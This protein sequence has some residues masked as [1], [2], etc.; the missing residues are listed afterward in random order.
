MATRASDSVVLFCSF[1]KIDT[2]EIYFKKKSL[3][4]ETQL[5]ASRHVFGVKEVI[6]VSSPSEVVGKCVAQM[7]SAVYDVRLQLSA[8][9]RVIVGASCTCKAGVRGWCKHGAALAVF[10]NSEIHTACTD[11]P[12]AWG[13]PSSRPV[14][15]Q[16][17]RV[18]EL[19]ARNKSQ[20]GD[21][22][23]QHAPASM[24]LSH[25]S[26]IKCPLA[27]IL[28]AENRDPIEKDCSALLSQM[29]TN[30]VDM[31]DKE[32]LVGLLSGKNKVHHV[33]ELT[34]LTPLRLQK[35][36]LVA[37]LDRETRALYDRMISKNLDEIVE[38]AL[39]TRG[40]AAASSPDGI[41]CC[42]DGYRLVE[43]KCP[44]KLRDSELIDH[45]SETSFVP[46]V[47]YVDGRLILKKSHSGGS[48]LVAWSSSLV[49]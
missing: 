8:Q 31:N 34:S 39:V 26:E 23:V 5:Y 1:K 3:K 30:I 6:H 14:R 16:R 32:M 7:K 46:Y 37:N 22:V 44:Y 35:H 17:K 25:F 11:R 42:D 38:I 21:P 24:L 45:R 29:V 47:K 4:L 27:E 33:M 36:D 9:P 19:F 18:D 43:I 12:C 20:L 41:V 28:T 2:I 49:E 40:Q 10:V 15:D 13:K 48:T